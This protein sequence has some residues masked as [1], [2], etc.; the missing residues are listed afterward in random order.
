MQRIATALSITF[1]FAA[2]GASATTFDVTTTADGADGSCDAHCTLREAVIAANETPG[3]DVINLPR[4]VYE[5]TL[6][7]SDEDACRTGD[8]DVTEQVNIYG[9]GWSET[10]IDGLASDRVFDLREGAGPVQIASITIRGGVESGG[11]G[12]RSGLSTFLHL[13]QVSFVG[14]RAATL[15]GAAYSRA[16]LVVADCA[17]AANT[18]GSLG[19]AI[20]SEGSLEVV[21]SIFDGNRT[22]NGGGAIMTSLDQQATISDSL[23]LANTASYGGAISV[24]RTDVTATNVTFRR[25]GA[26]VGSGGAIESNRGSLTFRNCT[27]SDDASEGNGAELGGTNEPVIEFENSIVSGPSSYSLCSE[28]FVS[29]GHNLATDSS[30]GL[31]TPSD[32]IGLDP[33]L[34]DLR[35]NSGPTPTLALLVGSP[36][37]DAG[38]GDYAATDQRGVPRPIGPGP[39][40]GAYEA[41]G[42]EPAKGLPLTIPVVAHVDGVGGTPW[43]TDVGI[44]N[45]GSESLE[46]HLR[47]SPATGAGAVEP[48]E[49]SAG[50]TVFF[51]DIV[52]SVLGLGNG[53]GV[54]EVLPP[55]EGPTPVVASRTYAVSGTDRLGQGM[56]ALDPFPDGIYFI[57]GLREDA[58][59]RSN[60]GVA[61]GDQNLTIQVDLFRGTD[62]LV[63]TTFTRTVSAGT[64]MQWRLSTM[65]PSLAVSGVPMTARVRIFGTGIPYGS[66]VDQISSD[67]VTLIACAP[68]PAVFVPVVAHNPG[69]QG[70]FWRSDLFLHNP[71]PVEAKLVAEYLPEATDNQ[72]GGLEGKPINI[73]A[74]GTVTMADVAGELFAVDDGKG[75]L[76]VTTAPEIVASSRT[77]TTN[78][79]GGTYGLGVAALPTFARTP[80]SLVLTGVRANGGFRTNLGVIGGER[81]EDVR[82]S[83]IDQSGS[84][85][86]TVTVH[87]EPRSLV[88]GS[89]RTLFPDVAWGGFS[90]G[91]VRLDASRQL[92][93]AYSSTVDDS[94]QDPIFTVATPIAD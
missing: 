81:S 46:V 75:V 5:L 87:V 45:P 49:I 32:L 33:A 94:S 22:V 70:T 82:V 36:A 34:R 68:S 72:N 79:G 90:V 62:G 86:G 55:D 42:D 61:A 65:F 44:T 28:P 24:D 6:N 51:E 56:P 78:P 19:G 50:G 21:R 27:F 84:V 93:A 63:G 25:N 1:I 16:G 15:G 40:I 67:A 18:S 80:R 74:F 58:D 53:Q 31:T 39:D 60:I 85:L 41:D 9:A 12:V 37:V 89:V 35:D 54:L 23:F 7:G 92:K 48:V 3:P 29:F 77:Y 59:Y 71:N 10:V 2:A 83:L 73:P 76:L 17:F 8:L 11:G 91:S 13:A 30:C 57:P 14:N 69:M 64:Q 26:S 66:L 52:S 20:M 47:Y 4:G 38:G 43:R 88:Q